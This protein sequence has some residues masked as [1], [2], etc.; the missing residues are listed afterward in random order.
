MGALVLS[1]TPTQSTVLL[2]YTLGK[3]GMA[4]IKFANARTISETSNNYLGVGN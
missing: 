4:S 1:R 3:T 2:M